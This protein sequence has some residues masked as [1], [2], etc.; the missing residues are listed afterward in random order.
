M[1]K[2]YTLALGAAAFAS[3]S[4]LYADWRNTHWGDPVD[5]VIA[6]VG[7]DAK[8][9][10]GGAGDRID[11]QDRLASS[12]GDLG[13]ISTRTEYFFDS[14][15]GL[16]LVQTSPRSGD[17]CDRFIKSFKPLGKPA[18]DEKKVIGPMTLRTWLWID[19]ASNLQTQLVLIS[20]LKLSFAPCHVTYMPN[21]TKTTPPGN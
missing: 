11:G 19:P 8:P 21:T 16:S 4:A 1:S 10:K 14:K 15:G 20:G 7:G 6:A 5:Q 13:G 12:T 2:I 18:S 9:D 17:D 3:S